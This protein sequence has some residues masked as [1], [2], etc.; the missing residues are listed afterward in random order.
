[1]R[2][3]ITRRG[4]VNNSHP[5]TGALQ[6]DGSGYANNTGTYDDD[7]ARHRQGIGAK[8]RGLRMVMIP[9]GSLWQRNALRQQNVYKL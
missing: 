4:A 7:M 3:A 2:G 1:M 9:F 8:G 5:R 6:P